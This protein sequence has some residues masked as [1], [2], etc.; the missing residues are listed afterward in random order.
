MTFFILAIIAW[1]ALALFEV[2]AEARY[3]AVERPRYT[4]LPGGMALWCVVKWVR[5]K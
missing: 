1:F 4:N 5:R 2:I 3:I